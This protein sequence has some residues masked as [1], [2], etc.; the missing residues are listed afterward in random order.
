M[1][2][3]D[4]KKVVSI[5]ILIILLLSTLIVAAAFYLK[6]L[7]KPIDKSPE[8]I[9]LPKSK[10][11]EIITNP[12]LKN[13]SVFFRLNGTLTNKTGSLKDNYSQWTVKTSVNR[14]INFLV[15]ANLKIYSSNPLKLPT[16]SSAAS[17]P[18]VAPSDININTQIEAYVNFNK[19]TQDLVAGQIN[20][21]Q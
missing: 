20:L 4:T 9:I 12:D 2:Q 11:T 3:N 13:L 19:D 1:E 6:S 21:F 15:P 18:L 7:A 8:T 16:A 14:K 17:I 10:L 5:F